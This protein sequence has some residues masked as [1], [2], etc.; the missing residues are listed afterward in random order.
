MTS[1]A[2]RI[3]LLHATPV[4]VEPVKQAFEAE[5]PEADLLNLLDDG[6]SQ[7][8]ARDTDLTQT[9]IERFV[10]LGHYA[11]STGA[12]GILV[13]C[14]AFGPAIEKLAGALPIPV[15]KPNEAM[16]RAAIGKGN[17]IG[18]IATFGP[19]I[20]TMEAEFFE[21]VAQVHSKA[22]LKTI[23]VEGAMVALRAGDVESHNRLI[24]ERALE[25]EWCDT[26]ML[27]HFSTARAAD[28]VQKNMKNP[29]LSAP[30]AA[31]LHMRKLIEG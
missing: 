5:W 27:A 1:A 28:L 24:A 14:S 7:D 17:K 20:G 16:F 21:Y 2:P 4:A 12:S 25:L 9:M 30:N 13:T 22:T 18:M 11:Y 31:V 19:S 8:R 6:L 15:L 10:S 23:L 26:I 29:I 3:V